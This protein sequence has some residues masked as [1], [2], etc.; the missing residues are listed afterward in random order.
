MIV[1]IPSLL[2]V[3]VRTCWLFVSYLF[4]FASFCSCLFVFVLVRLRLHVLACVRVSI[5][6]SSLLV[7]AS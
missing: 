2:L 1:R 5:C 3:A 6:S 7:F 4:A